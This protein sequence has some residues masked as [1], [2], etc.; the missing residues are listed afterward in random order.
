MMK[1]SNIR[2][3]TI[4]QILGYLR[5]ARNHESEQIMKEVWEDC[6]RANNDFNIVSGQLI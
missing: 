1:M 6:N 4:D 2:I 3:K 5:E